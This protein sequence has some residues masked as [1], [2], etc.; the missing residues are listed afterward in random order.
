MNQNIK[1]I[2]SE[3]NIPELMTNILCEY[4]KGLN[5]ENIKYISNTIMNNFII[6]KQKMIT[7]KI[8]TLFIIYTKQELL[9]MREKLFQ[10]RQNI[11]YNISRNN[12]KIDIE[13]I[14]QEIIIFI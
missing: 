1:N 14:I 9:S 5:D 6:Y 12:S 13:K 3:I 8:N 2:N 10:W 7:K 11:L 4:L